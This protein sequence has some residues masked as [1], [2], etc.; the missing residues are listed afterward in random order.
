[1]QIRM[2]HERIK[3]HGEQ[4]RALACDLTPKIAFLITRFIQSKLV[5]D[6][7]NLLQVQIIITKFMSITTSFT[8]ND[9]ENETIKKKLE[10]EENVKIFT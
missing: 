6:L 2:R 5:I 8:I 1:M 10:Y 9:D 7:W 4:L 3:M